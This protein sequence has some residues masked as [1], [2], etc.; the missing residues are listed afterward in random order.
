MAKR[1]APAPD[2]ALNTISRAVL[3]ADGTDAAFRRM[4][5]M[6]LS[7]THLVEAVR[8]GF[9]ALIGISGIQYEILM[10]VQRMQEARGISVGEVASWLQ[11]SGAFI[12]IESGKLARAG[13][14]EKRADQDDRRR[15]LLHLTK[16]AE[17]RLAALAPV[18]AEINDLLFEQM[19]SP[20]LARLSSL[21]QR[22]LPC[23]RRA[24][25]RIEERL[26]PTPA[27]V[28]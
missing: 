5:H 28:S 27:R 15:V 14:L 7:F 10:S 26:H 4:I 16:L 21:L 11:R 8:D 24:L 25:D 19:T 17:S 20:D 3:L 12:T 9:G 18:Q 23:G 1:P 2:P 22:L 13:W 6:L